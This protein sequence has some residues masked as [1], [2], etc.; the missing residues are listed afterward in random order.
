MITSSRDSSGIGVCSVIRL[1]LHHLPRHHKAAL[2]GRVPLGGAHTFSFNKEVNP[3][4]VDP[5]QDSNAYAQVS[6]AG[7]TIGAAT[8]YRQNFGDTSADR[9]VFGVGATYNWDLWTVGLG[10][11]RG[12]YEKA[13]GADDVGPFNA[14]HDDIALTAAYALA[15]GISV[16]G[17]LEYSRYE[18]NDAAGPD[19][20]GLAL[21]MGTAISF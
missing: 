9:L 2:A 10:W 19:S 12:D 21:G 13:V 7:F 16:N 18:S 5:A 11:T 20:R 17:L 6:Y 1:C 4:N 15:P 8:E 3:N 14:V